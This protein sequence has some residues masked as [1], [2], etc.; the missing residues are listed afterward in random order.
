MFANLLAAFWHQV[1]TRPDQVALV[2]SSGSSVASFTWERLAVKVVL[3]A[4]LLIQQ[5]GAAPDAFRFAAY[6]SDNTLGDVLMALACP[7]AGVI[8][9]PVDHRLGQSAKALADRIG[10]LWLPEHDL[11]SGQGSVTNVAIDRLKDA[12]SKVN[13]DDSALILWT[14]GTTDAPKAVTLT[15]RNLILNA[16]AKLAAVP[17]STND[18]RL[19]SLP[20]CHAY[21]RTCDLGT[22]LLSGCTLAMGLGFD[23]WL[24]LGPF[25]RPT[26]ANIVPSLADRLLN[27]DP[28][29][30]GIDRLRLLGCGGAAMSADDF[31][32]WKSQGITVIQGYGLTETSPVIC[33]ATP[34]NATAGLVGKFVDGWE[35]QVRDGRL[36]VRGPHLM[37][38]YWSDIHATNDRIKNGWLDT[39][40]LVEIDSATGQ[41][42][43]LGRAD[44]VI[45]LDNGH[46][47]HPQQIEKQIQQIAGVRHAMIV[48]AGRTIDLWLDAEPSDY[49]IDKLST[50]L[51][52]R[53]KWERPS[54]VHF[55]DRPLSIA[56]GELTSKGTIRRHQIRL[57]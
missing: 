44:D 41:L 33:S 24:R 48:A 29:T 28:R 19:T 55:F 12:S 16:A 54:A 34:E 2:L 7:V 35:H 47:V 23:A 30:V 13:A 8:E 52:G 45:V 26:V 20:L 3:Q 22:W 25:M 4:D 5:F 43:I 18:A 31:A 14:S 49:L 10:G 51:A 9:V 56:A 53:P 21:A 15:H 27:A 1:T 46:K 36:F 50:Q 57:S 39:G 40:D 32:A 6:A 37:A 42:R 38:G 11:T 17:D